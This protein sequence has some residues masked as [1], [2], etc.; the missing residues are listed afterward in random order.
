MRFNPAAARSSASSQLASRKCVQGLAGSI[1]SWAAGGGG[2]LPH[3]VSKTE[4]DL[5]ALAAPRHADDVVHLHFAAGADADR[6][7]DAGVE[8]DRHG[9]VAA[10]GLRLSAGGEA[11]RGDADAIGP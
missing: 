3:G 10:V 7:L 11:A 9:G 5:F 2:G 6:A 1:W 8:I 4:P